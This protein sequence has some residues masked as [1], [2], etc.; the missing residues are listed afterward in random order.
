MQR[1]P[2]FD[3]LRFVLCLGIAFFHYSFRLPIENTELQNVILRFSYFT[4]IFFILSGLFL[5]RRQNY[6]WN[7]RSYVAFIAKR[8]ARIYPLH[9][10]VFSCFALLSVLTAAGILHP[11]IQPDLSWRNALA[12][13]F[14]VHGWGMGRSFSYNYVSWSLSALF[15]MY[16]CFPCFDVLHRRYGGGVLI[17][18]IAA[19]IGGEYLARRLGAPS[20]TRVQFAD[21]GVL[22]ALPSFLFGMW[23]ARLRPTEFS[24]LSISFALIACLLVFLFYQ[25][26][27]PVGSGPTLEGPW[28]LLFLYVFMFVLFV[29]SIQ[30]IST[31]L[32][33]SGFVTFSRYSFGIFILHPLV[34]LL[35]FNALPATWGRS[36]ASALLLA[37]AGVLV[38]VFVAAIAWRLFENPVHRWLIGRIDAWAKRPHTALSVPN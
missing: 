33:W 11:N 27:Y 28:R 1:I 6:V 34:G 12:Q 31:P 13:L 16:L 7:R 9:V 19:V 26:S 17:L 4:D 32:R 22:R 5:A 8:L 3:G 29:A 30:G 37:S 25:P 38:S 21:I 2:D 18:V 10:A 36:V 23:L 15:L 35:F 20:L 14:L 24:R